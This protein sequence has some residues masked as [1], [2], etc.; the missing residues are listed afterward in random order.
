MEN[1]SLWS[2]SLKYLNQ[3]IQS[4]EY[5][6]FEIEAILEGIELVNSKYMIFLLKV[7]KTLTEEYGFI[8]A[9]HYLEIMKGITNLD[10][11]LQELNI[12]SSPNEFLDSYYL[13]TSI[14][15]NSY[16]MIK[17]KRK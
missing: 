13:F 3:N 1:L 11:I 15:A 14:L 5:S 9:K 8:V 2:N 17:E 4:G 12:S 6:E 10:S 7:V 16:S